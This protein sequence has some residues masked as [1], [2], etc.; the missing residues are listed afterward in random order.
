MVLR[1]LVGVLEGGGSTPALFWFGLLITCSI[2]AI[3]W[4]GVA[5]VMVRRA[6]L[7]SAAQHALWKVALFGPVV[8][9]AL[10]A[11]A[12]SLFER[13]VGIGAPASSLVEPVSRSPVLS[14]LADAPS[15]LWSLL[16]TCCVGIAALRVVRFF[17]AMVLLWLRVRARRSVTDGRL[18][19]RLRC[20][21]S[22]LALPPVRLTESGGVSGPLVLW[23]FEIC[24]PETG[25]GALTDTEVDA[26][27][28]HELAH[29]ERR[30]DLWFPLAGLAQAILWTQPMTGWVVARFR[31]TSELACDDRA[32]EMTG[33]AL[34][35]AKALT[36]VAGRLIR[37]PT[38]AVPTM[39]RST[40]TLVMR[41]ERL[42]RA[43]SWESDTNPRAPR[44]LLALLTSFGVVSA[45]LSVQIGRTR[46]SL[47]TTA[48]VDTPHLTAERVASPMQP[49]PPDTGAAGRRMGTLAQRERTLA[50]Q[51][52]AFGVS[53]QAPSRDDA[54]VEVLQLTQELRHVRAEE[55]WIEQQLAA[56]DAAGDTGP[57]RSNGPTP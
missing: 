26:V 13:T 5:M 9:T 42:A 50:A 43:G 14:A 17:G 18:L 48:P 6:A 1:L 22:R 19:T 31:E 29:L 57:M 51:L 3:L 15:V 8:T 11:G 38:A 45:V 7:S 28:A 34:G 20:L 33:D 12:P 21:Q 54:D 46:A 37:G 27:L 10:A 41:V 56:H 30:D 55:L 47:A 16:A 53:E 49:G 25:I 32:V 23:P 52:S 44:R 39:A 40:S 24:I 36:R 2:H 35:L 4:T